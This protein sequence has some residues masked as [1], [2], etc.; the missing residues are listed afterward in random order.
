MAGVFF[1]RQSSYRALIFQ[2]NII[3]IIITLYYKNI[4]T[5]RMVYYFLTPDRRF[6]PILRLMKYDVRI[7]FSHL[8]L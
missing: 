2:T 3:I 7:Y 4:A 6:I 8:A 1:I 5:R